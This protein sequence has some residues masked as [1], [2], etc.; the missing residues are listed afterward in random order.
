MIKLVIFDMD[1]LMF[2]TEAVT[3]RAF[4]EV[5]TA[6]GCHPEFSQYVQLLGLNSEDICKKY[7][8]MFGAEFEPAQMYARVG[9]RKN[10]IMKK[11]GVPVKKGLK[12]LLCALEDRGIKKAVASGSDRSVVEENLRVT[13]LEGHFDMILS[14]KEVKRGKPYPDAFL[15]IC[16][17]LGVSPEETLVLEDSANG[18][19]AA[20][21]GEIPVIQ[22]PDMLELPS[23]LREKCLAIE[24]SLDKVIKY[25]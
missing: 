14:T 20:I 25:L 22:I 4:S 6:A 11:E 13:G 23:E 19:E 12:E 8:E 5:W 21:A 2:D 17:T 15:L 9:S 24:E 3:Y 16:E 7:I 1:G 18:V 10:E